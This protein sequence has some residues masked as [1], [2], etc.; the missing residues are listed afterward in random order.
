MSLAPQA[1]GSRVQV[2]HQEAVHR[3]GHQRAE[4]GYHLQRARRLRQRDA[5]PDLTVSVSLTPETATVGTTVTATRTVTNNTATKQAVTVTATLTYPTG[6]TRTDVKKV[7]LAPGQ[8]DAQ[9]VLYT[10]DA[11]YP[12]G[13]YT[14]TVAA[15]NTH[16]T[17]SATA[18][19]TIT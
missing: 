16:G 1:G 7:S 6:Q 5:D 10:V 17:S 9:T 19:L 3:R 11:S 8:T 15:T 13:T 2:A 14:L 4:C 18:T 12:K